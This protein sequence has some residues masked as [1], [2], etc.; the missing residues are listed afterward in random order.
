[1]SIQISAP[2]LKFWASIQHIRV[3]NKVN[4]SKWIELRLS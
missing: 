4:N 3:L 1:M 2:V